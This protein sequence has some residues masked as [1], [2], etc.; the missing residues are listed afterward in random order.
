[1]YGLFA[2]ALK[3]NFNLYIFLNSVLYKLQE[4]T[5]PLTITHKVNPVR[6]SYSLYCIVLMLY[7]D[8]L[9]MVWQELNQVYIKLNT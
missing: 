3:H 7:S 5:A 4:P 8:Q 1:M 2:Y 9:L 6:I